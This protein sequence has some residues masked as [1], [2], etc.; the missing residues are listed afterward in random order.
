MSMSTAVR[1]C[2]RNWRVRRKVGCARLPRISEG[3]GGSFLISVSSS[4]WRRLTSPFLPDRGRRRS[5]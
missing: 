3:A 2:S 5:A 1:D 4:I